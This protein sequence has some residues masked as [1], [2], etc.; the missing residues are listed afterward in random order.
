MKNQFLISDSEKS[1]ILSLHE[2]RKNYHG[3]SLLNEQKPDNLMPGQPDNQLNADVVG[4][5]SKKSY[6]KGDKLLLS[7]DR[8]VLGIELTSGLRMNEPGNYDW[9]FKITNA[10]GSFDGT[11]SKELENKIGTL[12][13]TGSMVE[14]GIHDYTIWVYEKPGDDDEIL[15]KVLKPNQVKRR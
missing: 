10:T 5:E 13:R 12:G 7:F 2:S 4:G 1:R 15:Y 6:K 11:T 3:T 14:G 9:T 8:K